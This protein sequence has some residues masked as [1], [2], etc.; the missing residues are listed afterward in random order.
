MK[1]SMQSCEYINHTDTLRFSLQLGI[2][3]IKVGG[4]WIEL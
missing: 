4:I 1:V 2:F 3:Q